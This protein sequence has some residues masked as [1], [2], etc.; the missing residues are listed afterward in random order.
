MKPLYWIGP[1][2][3]VLVALGLAYVA[4]TNKPDAPK[5]ERVE[6]LPK[7]A[8]LPAL[9]KPVR[10]TVESEGT[11]Q[12]RT[13]TI[14]TPEVSGRILEVDEGLRAGGFF[15][16]GDLLLRID[17]FDF[18]VAL[19]RARANLAQSS[20]ALAEEQAAS[21]QAR[22]DWEAL[23]KGEPNDLV[24]RIPQ[25]QRAQANVSSD[26]AAVREAQ[27]NLER[28]EVRAPYDGRVIEK[29]VDVGQFVSSGPQ[30]QL[31]RIISIEKA[32]VR[33]PL[34]KDQIALLDLSFEQNG[35]EPGTGPSVTVH[36]S[37]GDRAYRWDGN[38]ERVEGAVD[39]RTRFF[40]VIAVVDNPYGHDPAQPNRPPLKPGMFVKAEIEGR[41]A[42]DLFV[43][44]RAAMAGNAALYVIDQ[45]GRLRL[46]NVEVVQGRPDSVLVSGGLEPGDAYLVS[47]IQ[48]PVEGMRVEA[49]HAET[50]QV[51]HAAPPTEIADKGTTA[52]SASAEG[53]AL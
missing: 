6:V 26:Q 38:L 10:L 32:E 40:F 36:T 51:L 43:V 48:F 47:P 21:R 53:G 29:F 11:V 15:N 24:L 49:E 22:R 20:L 52:V 23:G 41:T 18:E 50:G 7:V 8:V 31:A 16:E 14:L 3:I 4:K 45:N 1:L 5:E 17:A 35:M 27:R 25:L 28:T 12:A 44:P 42:G 37:F 19:E 30:S 13:E 2:A 46:R 39:Q 34:S 33:L 9:A